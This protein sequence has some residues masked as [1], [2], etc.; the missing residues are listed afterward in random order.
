M[1]H[2]EDNNTIK[3]KQPALS[4]AIIPSGMI[5]ILKRTQSSAQE[6]QGPSTKPPQTM[7]ATI[8]SE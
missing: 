3:V 2:H 8:N 7:G 6:K 4:P 1:R 5:A